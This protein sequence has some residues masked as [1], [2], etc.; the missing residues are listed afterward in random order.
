MCKKWCREKYGDVGAERIP[1]LDGM[2]F[3]ND[4]GSGIPRWET[5]QQEECLVCYI[6]KSV[7]GPRPQGWGQALE[8]IGERAAA[9]IGNGMEVPEC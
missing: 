4:D 8:R 3:F 2:I 1:P 6:P 5:R 7:S 9:I